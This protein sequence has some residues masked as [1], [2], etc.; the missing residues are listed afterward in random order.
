L[1]NIG[2]KGE[3]SQTKNNPL[4]DASIASFLENSRLRGKKLKK[5]KPGRAGEVE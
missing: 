2:I 3:I 1:R 5:G 4:N